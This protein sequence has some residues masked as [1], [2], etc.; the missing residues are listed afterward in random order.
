MAGEVGW[1]PKS[2][3]R[4]GSLAPHRVWISRTWQNASYSR[5]NRVK[6]SFSGSSKMNRRSTIREMQ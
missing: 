5:I 1:T 4:G 6:C 3:G 2:A